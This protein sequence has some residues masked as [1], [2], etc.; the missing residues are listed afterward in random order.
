[1]K[2]YICADIEGTC[3]FVDWEETYLHDPQATYH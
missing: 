2:V 1:M 3:G